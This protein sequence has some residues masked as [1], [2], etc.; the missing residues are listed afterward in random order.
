MSESRV[1]LITGSA[2]GIGAHL[3]RALI[4]R[5]FR[6]AACD[7]NEAGLTQT[8][9]AAGHPENAIGLALDITDPDNWESVIEA[10]VEKWGAVDLLLNVGGTLKPGYAHESLTADVDQHIDVNTKGTIYGC[11][12]AARQ[13][14]K[15]GRGHIVNVASLAGVSPV[16]GLNLY[17]A[18]KF[19]VR[20]FS[21]SI[22]Q[23]LAPLG[24]HVTVLCPDAVQTPMLDVQVGRRE[25]AMTFSGKRTP[26]TVEDIEA[27]LFARV[28]TRRP[29]VEVCLPRS[30][31][32]LAKVVNLFPSLLLSIAPVLQKKGMAQQE[33]LRKRKT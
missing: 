16:P 13:M 23:E 15:Q 11:Q 25:A 28:L 22:A 29:P 20:G 3:T 18:S 2:S 9:E 1:V 31:G 8:L 5:G 12:V 32:I 6:T 21:L 4:A 33:R 30:R 17:S 14:V 7:I 27:A 19:A 26:L 10:V 24:V